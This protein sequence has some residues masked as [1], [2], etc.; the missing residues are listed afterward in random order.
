MMI[1]PAR[2]HLHREPLQ[3]LLCLPLLNVFTLRKPMRAAKG[4]QGALATPGI[5]APADYP[6]C[7]WA[8]PMLGTFPLE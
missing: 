7:L 4:W 6:A 5:Q 8:V 3:A 2:W 1:T